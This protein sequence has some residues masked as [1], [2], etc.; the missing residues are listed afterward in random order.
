MKEVGYNINYD[1]ELINEY[2]KII[3]DGTVNMD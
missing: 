3:P 2:S 1:Q